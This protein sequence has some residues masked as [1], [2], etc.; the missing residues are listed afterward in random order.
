MNLYDVGRPTMRYRVGWRAVAGFAV[1]ALGCA[2]WTAQERHT[3]I[4]TNAEIVREHIGVT[5]TLDSLR[6]E[7]AVLEKFRADGVAALRSGRRGAYLG[8][9]A[10]ADSLLRR[11]GQ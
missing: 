8:I 6:V 10:A 9:L 2:G 11:V 5:H 3:L 4:A 7:Y 1:L